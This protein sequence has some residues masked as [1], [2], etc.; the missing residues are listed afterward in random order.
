MRWWE[1]LFRDEMTGY[2]QMMSRAPQ[3]LSPRPALLVVDVV[4]S[5]VG[6]RGQ[7]LAEA[8]AEYPTSCGPA[9]WE[10]MPH[11][12]ET[13][14][15]ARRAG[16]PVVYTTG[17]PGSAELFGGTVKGELGGMKVDWT[18]ALE[19]PDEIAPKPGELVLQKPKASAFFCTAL[20]AHLHRHHVDSLIVTGTTTCGC[21]RA[22]VVDGFSY[23]YPTF[24]VE[25]ACFD[26]SRLSHGVSLFE[27][28]AKYADVVAVKDVVG[29]LERLAA[30]ALG[31]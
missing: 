20:V 24:V 19:I 26:R 4:R 7:T 29:W 11:L 21:V 23:G 22:T 17:S 30:A 28:N 13:I 1:D 6:R 16:A 31:R 12:A 15:A 25:E 27:M 14:D 18:T 5:F 3:R 2:G 8:A 10:A 9:A